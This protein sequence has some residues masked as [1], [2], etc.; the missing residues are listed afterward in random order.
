MISN[1]FQHCILWNMKYIVVM[2]SVPIQFHIFDSF[3]SFR[4]SEILGFLKTL[5]FKQ[6]ANIPNKYLGPIGIFKDSDDDY[7]C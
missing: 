4:Y 1:Y 2:E 5:R 3:L 6:N 7:K